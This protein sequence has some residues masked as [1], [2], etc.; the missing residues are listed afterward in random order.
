LKIK[1]GAEMAVIEMG[2]NHIGEIASYC[3]IVRPSFGLITN[4][5]KAHL[6]G[7]GSEEGVRKGKGELFDYLRQHGGTAFVNSN[8]SYLKE[9]SEGILKREFYGD[10]SAI[11]TD[12]DEERLVIKLKDG[13]AIRTQLAGAYNQA[14]VEA[15]IA[16]GEYFKIPVP[17]IKKSLEE[18]VPSNNRSQLTDWKNNKVI[19]DAYNANPT[20]TK[21]AIENLAKIQADHKVVMLGGMMEL[22]IESI[23]EHKSIIDLLNTYKWDNVIL[24]GGDYKNVQHNYKYFDT[25]E[26]VRRWF[27]DQNF[28]QT[29]L[30]IKGSHSIK[31]EK[32]L[33]D[34]KTSFMA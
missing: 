16:I 25:S 21:A 17:V 24:V 33:E 19:L 2:A 15:A 31:M 26:E 4:C 14:N 9:M 34:V 12:A 32:I 20:S 5:G 7:F 6:E 23:Q 13:T 8:L 3:E 18:Y 27:N 29:Y 1:S 30:L 11:V 22:G 28:I 10:R